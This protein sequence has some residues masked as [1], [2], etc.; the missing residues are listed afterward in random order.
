MAGPG[1]ELENP[2]LAAHGMRRKREGGR[3]ATNQ[4]EQ[5]DG[6]ATGPGSESFPHTTVKDRAREVIDI[7]WRETRRGTEF[8]EHDFG[9]G[10]K[11]RLLKETGGNEG[12][13]I[14]TGNRCRYADR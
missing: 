5:T 4:W 7:N 9:G 6:D 10:G 13:D 1:L 14:G 3:E 2:R 11:P 12:T 8:S